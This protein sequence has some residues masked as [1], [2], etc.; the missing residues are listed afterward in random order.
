VKIVNVPQN[1]QKVYALNDDEILTLAKWGI[2]IEEHYQKPMDIE[3][4]KM[5]TTI[6]FT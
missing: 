6:N 4:A 5:A 2:E 3:W 1:E